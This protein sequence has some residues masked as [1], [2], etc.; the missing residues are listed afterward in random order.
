MFM[1]W[2]IIGALAVV[3][4][5]FD[6]FFIGAEYAK[7]MKRATVLKGIASFFFVIL[8]IY[9]SVK[10]GTSFGWLIVAGLALG[11]IGDVLL[12]MRFLYEGKKSRIIFGVG[13]LAF[14]SGHI[15]YIVALIMQ[16]TSI[17]VPALII[18]AILSVISIPLIM[19]RIIAPSTGLKIFGCVY[20][21]IVIAMFSCA[22]VLC[23][24]KPDTMTLLFAIAGLL[25]AASDFIMIYYSFGKSIKPLRA[26]NLSLYYIAQLLI[27]A[28][29]FL[30]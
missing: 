27:A 12:N 15:M 11:M 16:D 6:V 24:M 8:G 9:C 28:C 29:I 18:T 5:V 17:I 21:A 1:E 7:R 23:Y 4:A 26:I 25:F 10:K 13:I 19:R 20:L 30:A 3:G 22:A 14:L 2:L